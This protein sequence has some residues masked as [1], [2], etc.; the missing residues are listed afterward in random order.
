MSVATHWGSYVA[1][2]DSGRLV[3]IE[4]RGDYPAPSPIGPGMV[5]A[6]ADSARVLRPAVRKGWLNG[7]SR[8]GRRR[9]RT[10]GRRRHGHAPQ[11]TERSRPGPARARKIPTAA[12]T[13]WI[14]RP[15]R[16]WPPASSTSPARRPPCPT[17]PATPWCCTPTGS[18]NA[19]A[20]TSTP[21]CTIAA[22]RQ[23]C[24]GG[25]AAPAPRTGGQPATAWYRLKAA[26]AASTT[27]AT[28]V[29]NRNGTCLT[30]VRPPRMPSAAT[31]HS[32]ATEPIPTDTGAP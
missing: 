27:A 14:R 1:V 16:P 21:A 9:P 3:R 23:G 10:G 12:A 15:T 8:R 2:V 28:R 17:P 13:C 11:R 4:P 22:A 30:R 25:G 24:G 18:S 31:D 29:M 26:N 32:P 7:L 20:R 19:A 6:A 5:R